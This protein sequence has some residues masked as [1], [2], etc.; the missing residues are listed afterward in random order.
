MAHSTDNPTP[1]NIDQIGDAAA[2]ITTLAWAHGI[3]AEP[4]PIDAFADPA[5]RLADAEV[6][7][8]HFERLL[9]RLAR[10]GVVTDDERFALHT[11]HLRQKADAVRPLR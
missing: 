6:T 4:D 11:L 1:V 5:S 9:L 10:A 8:D 3:T 2:A 7:F